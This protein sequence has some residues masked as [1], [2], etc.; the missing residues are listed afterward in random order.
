MLSSGGGLAREGLSVSRAVRNKLRILMSGP[1]GHRLG[2]MET[3]CHDYLKTS[4][5]C[6]FDVTTCRAILVESA[7]D[8]K[9]LA[10]ACLRT[11][12]AFLILL[13][14][15]CMLV[16]KRPDVVHV[17]TNSYAGFYVKALM[18]L[19]GRLVGAR[20]AL[21]MHGAE[22]KEFYGRSSG[23]VQ[24]LIRLLILGNSVLIVL[25]N[26]WRD[27]FL[28]IGIGRDKLVV[29]TNSVF[30]PAHMSKP[31]RAEH[32]RVLFLGR[33]ERRKGIYELME[34]IVRNED[35]RRRCRFI[36]VGP[37]TDDW[38]SIADRVRTDHL[39]SSVELPGAKSGPEKEAAFRDADVFL[40]QSFNEGMPIALLEAMSH[41]LACITSP[42]GGIP[43]VIED[44]QN[45]LLIPPG[46]I[47]ALAGAIR[48]LLDE[49]GLL[50]QLQANARRTIERRYNWDRRA[51]QL[52]EMYRRLVAGDAVISPRQSNGGE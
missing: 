34:A 43:Q 11:L 52:A 8:A 19:L 9:G 33:F 13:V 31:A 16:W 50:E 45:G 46:D 21:H 32:L 3:Y 20:S 5:V 7:L 25:S 39:E 24:R 18:G 12:N 22:F 23:I 48:R 30:V 17:H 27:F 29:M 47:G 2:G 36:L 6:W 38:S 26:E 42:V 35:L 49:P 37:R 51:E 40:L 14:W 10:R 28:S 44:G 15:V 4:L 1:L 41:G